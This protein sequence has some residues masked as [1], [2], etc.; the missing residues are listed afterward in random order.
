MSSHLHF[1]LLVLLQLLFIAL[2]SSPIVSQDVAKVTFLSGCGNRTSNL[3]V[4]QCRPG[5]FLTITGRNFSGDHTAVGFSGPNNSYTSPIY[6]G[7]CLSFLVVSST[8]IRCSLPAITTNIR[9]LPFAIRLQSFGLWGEWIDSAFTYGGPWV[10]SLQGCRGNDPRGFTYW[11]GN[12]AQTLTLTGLDFPSDPLVWVAMTGQP[13]AS[14]VSSTQVTSGFSL[15]QY[16]YNSNLV[17]GVV[18]IQVF[19]AALHEYDNGRLDLNTRSFF[20]GGPPFYGT[21]GLYSLAMGTPPA[22]SITSVSGCL[23]RWGNSTAGCS[24]KTVLEISGQALDTLE[25]VIINEAALCP[26]P[27]T[28]SQW[29]VTCTLPEG[30]PTGQWL[31]VRVHSNGMDSPRFPA[32]LMFNDPPSITAVNGCAN[33]C[34][35]GQTVTVVGSAFIIP[36]QVCV[37]DPSSPTLCVNPSSS[38]ATTITL[39]LPTLSVQGRWGEVVTVGIFVSAIGVQGSLMNV[40][41]QFPAQPSSPHPRPPF[42]SFPPHPPPRPHL[43]PSLLLPRRVQV[44]TP[45]IP[46]D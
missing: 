15:N 34:K 22:P 33:Q 6:P 28:I 46:L 18:P 21:R 37:T 24:A 14:P 23:S 44:A 8:T 40:T 38:T 7:T 39:T 42:L 20:S 1:V 2:L 16:D 11:C 29:K 9:N 31:T 35:A 3:S 25:A 26:N 27:T 13:S 10:T 45:I 32:A 41:W 5:A 43:L 17:N 4:T 12:G 30:Q 19:S 36:L